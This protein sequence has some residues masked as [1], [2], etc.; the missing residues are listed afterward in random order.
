MKARLFRLT[1]KGFL[2]ALLII[3]ILAPVCAWGYQPVMVDWEIADAEREGVATLSEGFDTS[4]TI[5]LKNRDQRYGAIVEFPSCNFDREPGGVYIQ[6]WGRM[7]RG[8]E[9]IVRQAASA[10]SYQPAWEACF[11]G[12]FGFGGRVYLPR[13]GQARVEMALDFR[14]AGRIQVLVLANVYLVNPEQFPQEPQKPHEFAEI[15]RSG[16][17]AAVLPI[18]LYYKVEER[19]FSLTNYLDLFVPV[20]ATPEGGVQTLDLLETGGQIP[21][22]LDEFQ[23]CRP[24]PPEEYSRER[25]LSL[26]RQIALSSGF[27]NQVI[28]QEPRQNPCTMG[29]LAAR[30]QLRGSA[31]DPTF[32]MSGL[33]SVQWTDHALH[34]AFGWRVR[35]WWNSPGGWKLM[36]EDWIQ[37]DGTWQLIFSYPGYTGQNL[38]IQYVAFNRYFTPQTGSGDTYR[39]IGPDRTGVSTT[40]NEG[41]WFAD[42]DGG[43]LRGLG[44]VYNEGMTMW[45]TLYWTGEIDPLRS[46]SLKLYFPNTTND[47]GDGTGVPWSCAYL[48]GR[49]YLIPAHALGKGVV[50]HEFGHQLNYEYW[51]NKRPAASGGSHNLGNCYTCGLALL[52][53]FANFMP[54]WVQHQARET[55]PNPADFFMDIESPSACQDD[56]NEAWVAGTFW[57]LHDIH[58]DGSDVLWYI[59]PGAVIAIYL[60]NGVANNG[61]NRCMSDYRTI[62]RNRCTSGHETYID[63]IF[64]QNH[65][66]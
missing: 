53:G 5:L 7:M 52:E 28:C 56:T 12:L 44:E 21:L 24:R 8:E 48:D 64:Q 43:D 40:H 59:H 38:R 63:A 18:D 41:A 47:C 10:G 35:A 66:D 19:R 6:N 55:A 11:P 36:A 30:E 22:A 17:R 50:Q 15:L 29:R 61:D 45:S 31:A 23:I 27:G 33:F 34:P 1:E 58:A 54:F 9:P 16:I 2:S 37:W 20:L 57:D 62:Y 60:T 65:T 49:V 14:R 32:T 4:V 25:S 51:D 26:I 13:S 3:L 42:C 46:E 39:W